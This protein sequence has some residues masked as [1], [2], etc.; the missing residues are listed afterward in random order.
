MET[1]SFAVFILTHGRPDKVVTY[2]TLRKQ[3]YTG[4][5]YI[6]IDNEDKAA[7]RYRQVYG[8]KVIV[9]DKADIAARFDEGDNFNDRRAVFYARNACFDIA[10]N[11]GIEYFLQLDDDYI[12]FVYKFDARLMYKEQRVKNLDRLLA[13]V[14][15]YYKS[16]PAATIAFAQNGDFLGGAESTTGYSLWLKRKSMNT[17]FCSVNRPFSFVGRV[18]EDVNTYVRLGHVGALMFSFFNAAIIQRQTQLS[19][20]GMTEMYLDSGTFIKS[21]Y[22]VMYSPSCVTVHET[23]TLHKRIH[24]KI[25]WN[26]A[27]PCIVAERHRKEDHP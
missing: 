20:G 24:H 23:G 11:L 22:T 25:A 2:N 19:A 10:R 17:F 26:K 21:F 7:D 8:D 16:I 4:D 15:D 5:V 6:V 1:D 3:G 9:F 14:L 12:A 18:N 27:V 13:L